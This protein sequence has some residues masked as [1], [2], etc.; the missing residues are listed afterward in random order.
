MITSSEGMKWTMACTR[1]RPLRI[2]TPCS[3]LS[4]SPSSG[5]ST[6]S[7]LY[8]ESGSRCMTVRNRR[9]TAIDN[10]AANSDPAKKT[11]PINRPCPGGS[12]HGCQVSSRMDGKMRTEC[13]QVKG[14]KAN[15]PGRQSPEK[16]TSSPSGMQTA[17]RT[18]CRMLIQRARSYMSQ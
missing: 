2:S 12:G 3:R 17:I 8:S 11:P 9:I 1:V 13:S 4:A 5:E 6:P 14:K 16:K 10:S 18:P 7:K 15:C